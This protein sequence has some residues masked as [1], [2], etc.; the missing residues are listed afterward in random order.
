MNEWEWKWKD[1]GWLVGWSRWGGGQAASRL[2]WASISRYDGVHP[3]CNCTAPTNE[4]RMMEGDG[5]SEPLRGHAVSS[6][7]LVWFGSF[8]VACSGACR[9][10]DHPCSDRIAGPRA[11]SLNLQY[12]LVYIHHLL[13]FY[14]ILLVCTL[15]TLPCSRDAVSC[16]ARCCRRDL[17]ESPSMCPTS[18]QCVTRLM[19]SQMCNVVQGVTIQVR[20]RLAGAN[21][22]RVVFHLHLD[23]PL[24]GRHVMLM[25]SLTHRTSVQYRHDYS[26]RLRWSK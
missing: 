5:A 11:C 9:P 20:V 22:S 6:C 18:S 4:R 16:Q 23:F 15:S 13:R 1:D 3:S 25:F 2:N 19:Q 14:L 8:Q 26:T 10:P 21:L 17:R 7:E 12:T 24:R